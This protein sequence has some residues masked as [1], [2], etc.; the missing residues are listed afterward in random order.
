MFLRHHKRKKKA[1]LPALRTFKANTAAF[2]A[3]LRVV[4]PTLGARVKQTL[5]L[6]FSK[7]CD[8]TGYPLIVS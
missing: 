3:S 1:I 4:L 7:K 2:S 5:Q 6:L 8:D